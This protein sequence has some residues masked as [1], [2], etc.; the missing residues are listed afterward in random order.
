[1]KK[2]F[3]IL[4]FLSFKNLSYS[5]IV[6]DQLL[7]A[8]LGVNTASQGFLQTIQQIQTAS[9]EA[10]K[11]LNVA[12]AVQQSIY[13]T[14]RTTRTLSNINS[15][16]TNYNNVINAINE[17]KNSPEVKN[18]LKNDASAV[19]KL[20]ENLIKSSTSLLQLYINMA[21]N[22]KN[23]TADNSNTLIGIIN[24]VNKELDKLDKCTI[25]LNNALFSIM[26]AAK[27]SNY[28]RSIN[29]SNFNFNKF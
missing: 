7:T 11:Y 8:L 2:I 26:N 24:N 27:K 16:T 1:M 20:T 21:N 22:A 28:S 10:Q 17:S 9:A 19:L 25:D 12:N 13:V 3:L 4:I 18:A 15:V 14:E 5:Q 23:L 29:V 6:S